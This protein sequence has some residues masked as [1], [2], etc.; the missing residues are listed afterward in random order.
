MARTVAIQ[1][2][3]HWSEERE[4][5]KESDS[6]VRTIEYGSE[7][8]LT[9]HEERSRNSSGSHRGSLVH[10]SKSKVAKISDEGGSRLT[11]GERVTPEE[12]LRKN[13]GRARSV[14]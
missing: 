4:R 1:A 12:P 11:E 13:E 6:G 8:E 10:V 14:S 5:K 7:P 3:M 9:D 2:N